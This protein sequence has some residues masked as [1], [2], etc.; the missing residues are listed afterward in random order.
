MHVMCLGLAG[1]KAKSRSV[2]QSESRDYT[3]D[4]KDA[5]TVRI[6]QWIFIKLGRSI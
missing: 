5:V 6:L 2:G 4:K 1:D 3:G